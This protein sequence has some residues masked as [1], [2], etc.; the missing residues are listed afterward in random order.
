M[1]KMLKLKINKS[2]RGYEAGEEVE[3]ELNQWG[4]PKDPYWI[5]RLDEAKIDKCVEIV[6]NG[7]K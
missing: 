4:K 6:K 2:I 1:S 5:N 7:R 3:I